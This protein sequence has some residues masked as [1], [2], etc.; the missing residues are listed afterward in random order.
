MKSF[1]LQKETNRIVGRVIA[2]VFWLT[3]W[4][5]VSL[6]LHNDIILVSPLAV[7][8]KLMELMLTSSFW[9]TILH[10]LIRILSGFF[11]GFV[12]AFLASFLAYQFKWF[13][14]LMEP[15]V[16]VVKSTPVASFI[17][18]VLI[19]TGPNQLAVFIALIMVFP[20]IYTNLLSGL[21]EVKKELLEMAKVFELSRWK[22][23]RF[24]YV[25]S[26]A[27]YCMASLKLGLGLSFKAGI[28]AEVIG[29]PTH[30]IG[31]MLYEA[32]I[33][34]MTEELLAWTVAIIVLSL[35]TEKVILLVANKLFHWNM[36]GV[37]Q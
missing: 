5:V 32:K 25:P 21:F 12:L 34:L 13:E 1:T 7:G 29:L 31:E 3:I 9:A 36:G 24:L 16:L 10:S 2:V 30:S 4:F 11:L 6:L 15:A 20:V 14:Q 22:K 19:W 17:I 27:P 8:K 18:L 28:A 23:F 37:R 26:I 35:C 33:Y